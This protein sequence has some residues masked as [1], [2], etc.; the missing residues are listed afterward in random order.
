MS[1]Y[2]KKE[3]FIVN[4]IFYGLIGALLF[5]GAKYLLPV[6]MPFLLGLVVTLMLQPPIR[7]V[8][9][10][11]PRLK[12]LTAIVLCAA[13]YA[14]CAYLVVNFGVQIFQK[15][16]DMIARIPALYESHIVPALWMM[17]AKLDE[18]LAN[19][20]PSFTQ[21]I[22]AIFVDLLQ[23]MRLYITEYSMKGVGLLTNTLTMIPGLFIKVL[24]TIISTFFMVGDFDYL[25]SYA[26][27]LVPSSR[28]GTVE[29]TIGYVKHIIGKYV[30]SYSLIFFITFVEL[31]TGFAL[32][33]VPN[34]MLLGLIVA[35]FD[36][37]PILGTGGVLI[38]WA[39]IAA[40]LGNGAFA[41]GLIVLYIVIIVVRNIIEPRIVG[42][43]IGLHPLVTLVSMF[44]GLKLFG[45]IGLF[46]FP[47]ALSVLVNM[48]RNNIIRILPRDDDDVAP[49]ISMNN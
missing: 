27:K 18:F 4:F 29:T 42:K 21:E 46:G 41:L 8:A 9:K 28:R 2:Q 44:V 48:D 31:S 10:K 6:L 39:I 20:D 11:K 22:D 45:V 13:F 37:L 40:V 30:K 38:P 12:R 17:Y 14:L 35:V 32:L 49:L 26:M 16:G 15:I 23:N 36:I 3:R 24:L 1:S 19:I 7:L 5:V 33:S 43:Q 34:P 47:I 25:A